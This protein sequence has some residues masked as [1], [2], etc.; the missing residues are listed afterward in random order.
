MT[1]LYTTLATLLKYPAGEWAEGL[2]QAKA[3]SSKPGSRLAS[4]LSEFLSAV[5]ST[6]ITRL[7][8]C[9]TQTFDL[10]PV[11]TLDV[12]HHLFGEDYKRGFFL[13]K[14]RETEEIHQIPLNRELPDYLPSVLLLLGRLPQGELRTDLI[15]L[16]LVPAVEKMLQALSK[17]QSPYAHLIAAVEVLL[18]TDGEQSPGRGSA[19]TELSPAA[20]P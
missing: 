1:D 2:K 11:C 6:S 3:L 5:R 16:C 18:K 19:Q 17:S 14:L 10:N 7:Q 9:Y 8:E 20:M 15:D 12:G 4:P 13:A